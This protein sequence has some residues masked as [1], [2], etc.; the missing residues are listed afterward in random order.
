MALIGNK[1]ILKLNYIYIFIILSLV[2]IKKFT[3]DL[4]TYP[5][6]INYFL[7]YLILFGL[8]VNSIQKSWNRLIPDN[9]K[10]IFYIY[11]FYS[12]I[13]VIIGLFNSTSY[14]DYKYIFIDY[15]PFVLLS[16]S[17]F[18]GINFEENKYFFSFFI[19]KLFPIVL[20][21]SIF[22]ISNNSSLIS[23]LAI[24]IFIFILSFYYIEK[25]TKLLV[26]A[27]SLTVIFIDFYFRTNS[28]RI[29][30]C[31]LT[32]IMFSFIRFKISLINIIFLLSVIAPIFFLILGLNG[33]FDILT[34]FSDLID[35]YFK[36]DVYK[37][38]SNT[39][40]F[41][42][43]EVLNS[44]SKKKS[45][46]FFGSGASE[47]YIS[48]YF[49]HSDYILSDKGRLA[50]EVGFL[51]TLLKS[52]L[53]GVLLNFLMLIYPAYLGINHSKNNLSK[54]F[55]FYLVIN[56]MLFFVEVLQTISITNF[57][58][59]IIIGICLSNKFRNLNNEELKTFFKFYEKNSNN[60]NK[61]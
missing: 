27:L 39:R 45:N 6:I 58:N 60:I 4:I 54:L 17:I 3:F 25:K 59:Y 35:Q 26:I 1:K 23:R 50:S 7:I 5:P 20:I 14:W 57:I 51:T 34:Y 16:F 56:W 9:G 53:L 48:R 38:G 47:G 44:I 37:V 19:K 36:N 32:L 46:I 30:M 15:I 61:S 8:F 2:E 55:G 22:F 21:L 42:Y 29:F 52:G 10:K 41:I 24:P 12:L 43:E 13:V 11:W 40:T 33:S 28:L 49:N 31:Y 18:I